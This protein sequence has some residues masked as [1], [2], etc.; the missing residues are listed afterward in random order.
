MGGGGWWDP[1]AQLLYGGAEYGGLEC[2]GLP[3]D[4]P[5]ADAGGGGLK[6]YCECCDCA[7]I[8]AGFGSA[9]KD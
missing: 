4:G 9:V 6:G 2:D 8:V 1:Y 7:Y 5:G 3:A